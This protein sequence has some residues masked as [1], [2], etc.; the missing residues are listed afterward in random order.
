M[1]QNS[2]V[3]WNS[4]FYACYRNVF[5]FFNPYQD[6]RMYCV[7]AL[8]LE[9]VRICIDVVSVMSKMVT[10]KQ[11]TFFQIDNKQCNLFITCHNNNRDE[12]LCPYKFVLT[13]SQYMFLPT[14]CINACQI[15]MNILFQNVK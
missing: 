13:I 2:I 1:I 4:S 7:S 14:I 5:Q 3:K 6:I 9:S 8:I 15:A 10:V 12:M 11:I